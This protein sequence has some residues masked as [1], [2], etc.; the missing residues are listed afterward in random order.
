MGLFSFARSFSFL[1]YQPWQASVA[2][3]WDI[4]YYLN[5]FFLIISVF[6][7]CGGGADVMPGVKSWIF[8]LSTV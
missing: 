2:G 7:L 8:L 6:I 3:R 4:F 5:S 1:L